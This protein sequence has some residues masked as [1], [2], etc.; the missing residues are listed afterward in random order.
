MITGNTEL[1]AHIG[2]PTHAFKAPMIYNPYF[3]QAGIDAVVVPMGCK[4]EDYPAFLRSV[5]SLANIRGALITMPHKVTTAGLLDEVSPTAQIAGACNAVRRNADGKL[6]GDMFDGEGF[7]RGVQRKGLQLQGIR[8]VVVGCGGVGSAI[9][10]SLAAAGVGTL[11]L[12]DAYGPSMDGLAGRL[13]QHYPALVVE[14]GSNDPADC[15]LV[16]NATP[17]G[18]NDGDPLPMDV[19]RIAPSAFVGEVVMKAETTA[20]L[21]AAQARGCRVQV[22]T[23]MLF[24]QIP[25][26]LE[27]FG[28]PTTTP[29]VL[30][31]VATLKY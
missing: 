20:F 27:F 23:D 3:D 7:V 28:L 9:A 11:R 13:R 31:S 21:A 16:V 15:D 14:T 6:V 26:Y 25:A 30:R 24:E 18:M 2:F 5:F 1:I 19:S 8:A 17:M 4:A 22:G 10:A 12:Y 29:E